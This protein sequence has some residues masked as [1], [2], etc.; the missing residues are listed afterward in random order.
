M[1][2]PLAVTPELLADWPLPH[3]AADSDKEDRGR[4][5]DDFKVASAALPQATAGNIRISSTLPEAEEHI[6]EVARVWSR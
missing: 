2:E 3:I 1:T 5:P 4:I 6:A